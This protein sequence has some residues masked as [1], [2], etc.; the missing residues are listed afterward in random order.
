MLIYSLRILNRRNRINVTLRQVN[1]SFK[2]T[3]CPSFLLIRRLVLTDFCHA[4]IRFRAANSQNI[5]FVQLEI[6][7]LDAR[8]RSSK[9]PLLGGFDSSN[10]HRGKHMTAAVM[11]LSNQLYFGNNIWELKD[12]RMVESSP[13]RPTGKQ[14]CISQP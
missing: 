6:I 8:S 13:Y 1:H 7:R 10:K 11:R 4:K 14:C 2:P 12:C 5:S 9:H 3:P